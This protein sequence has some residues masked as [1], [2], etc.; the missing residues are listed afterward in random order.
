MR[1]NDVKIYT[2]QE[3]I[4]EWL[5][6]QEVSV[7]GELSPQEAYKKHLEWLSQNF[8]CKDENEFIRKQ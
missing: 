1:K 3:V 5:N 4:N 2:S 6:R 8:I 7:L